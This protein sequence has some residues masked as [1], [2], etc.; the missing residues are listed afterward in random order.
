MQTGRVGSSPTG[1]PMVGSVTLCAVRL[2]PA[3]LS[4]DDLPGSYGR[5]VAAVFADTGFEPRVHGSLPNRHCLVAGYSSVGLNIA[6]DSNRGMVLDYTPTQLQVVFWCG[7]GSFTTYY[8]E[9]TL[10]WLPF[11]LEREAVP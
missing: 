3:E 4:Y 6:R 11:T 2:E 9:Y 8:I 7:Y 1:A 5:R 10:P